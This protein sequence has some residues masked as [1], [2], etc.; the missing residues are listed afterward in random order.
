MWTKATGNDIEE[1][2]EIFW[3]NIEAAPQYISHGEMQ[4][5]VATAPETLASNGKEVWRK[6]ISQKIAEGNENVQLPSSVIVYR[7]N[8]KIAAFCVLAVL[9]DGCNPYGVI[10]DMLVIPQM[11]GTGLGKELLVKAKEWFKEHG[12]CDVYLESGLN[13]HSAHA[14]FRKYGF[15]EVSHI[16]K[17]M[18]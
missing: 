9:E 13:N 14:F 5:G 11:R 7:N 10:C 6:Y 16:F 18:E 3:S 1:L 15:R 17:L 4:M 2:V 12:I 8:G